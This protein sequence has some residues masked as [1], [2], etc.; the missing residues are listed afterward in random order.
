MSHL[1][2]ETIVSILRPVIPDAEWLI[3]YLEKS[4]GV[5]RFPPLLVEAI[6]NL[7]IAN[8][9]LLFE[10]E[11]RIASVA[12][13]CWLEEDQIREFVS[14]LEASTL[15][16]RGRHLAELC[17]SIDPLLTSLPKTQEEVEQ[18]SLYLR[19]L[20]EEQQRLHIRRSQDFLSFFFASFGQTLSIMV[21]GE[22]LTALVA[23]AKLGDD[24]SF[25]KAIQIDASILTV[26]PYFKNRFEQKRKLGDQDVIDKVTYRISSP[27]YRG[28]IKHKSLFVLLAILEQAALLDDMPLGQVLMICDEIGV[29]GGN[30]RIPDEAALGKLIRRYRRMQRT[31]SAST[32]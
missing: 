24:G 9:P 5:I 7:Q 26:I 4:G 1:D 22:K 19:S 6:S 13:R 30:S 20:S 16:D 29:G 18:R 23:K 2:L 14:S 28:K 21:H 25:F 17:A 31:G 8:Y 27:P 15:E 12:L 10:D 32:H 3:S 11:S